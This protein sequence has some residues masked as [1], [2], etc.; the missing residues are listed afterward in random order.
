MN[1][2]MIL[3]NRCS[4]ARSSTVHSI[5]PTIVRAFLSLMVPPSTQ[6]SIRL[7]RV[8]QLLWMKNINDAMS[9]LPT[10]RIGV[11]TP[12]HRRQ[13]HGIS[14]SSHHRGPSHTDFEAREPHP[15]CLT[16]S[17]DDV[18]KPSRILHAIDADFFCQ[19]EPTK[20]LSHAREQSPQSVN[21]VI[22]RIAGGGSLILG[23]QF[24]KRCCDPWSKRSKNK[25]R[26]VR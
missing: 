24:N 20:T 13:C 9:C 2:C 14:T 11:S 7:L 3:R 8:G 21:A 18:I 10:G 5:R 12:A 15:S 17:A 22:S 6:M 19:A 1:I 25:I 4:L 26:I 16:L 23:T